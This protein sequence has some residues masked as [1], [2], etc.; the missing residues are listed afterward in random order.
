MT[1]PVFA[2]AVVVALQT[3][4]L[5]LPRQHL[6]VRPKPA[7]VLAKVG[8]VPIKATDL[9]PYLWDWRAYEV[10]QDA[11][12][13]Q[14]IAAEARAQKVSVTDAEVQKLLEAQMAAM[15]GQLRPGQTL[16]KAMLEQGFPKNRL[17]L[18]L[19]SEMLL[20]KLT[21]KRFNSKLFVKVSTIII[22][23][24]SE[25]ASELALAVKRAEDAYAALAGGEPW[26]DV[27]SR[28]TDDPGTIRTDGL[29]GWRDLGAF[30]PT[31]RQELASKKPGGITK[32]AQTQNGI[33]IFRIES[34]GSEASGPVLEELREA[35][36]TGT[37]QKVL[38]EIR[39]KAKI[40][41]YLGK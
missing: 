18:R 38:E 26:S 11:I 15:R 12:T 22:R 21:L 4:A 6:T 41:V 23:P 5:Q 9:E 13:H 8:G 2:F 36:L 3:P 16:A 30:P 27:L 28:F 34:L 20:D 17:F 14:M 37:R 40:E 32:P 24:K 10:L 7:A 19:R 1:L 31:V 39:A 25:Q 33:Q 35:F 29:L